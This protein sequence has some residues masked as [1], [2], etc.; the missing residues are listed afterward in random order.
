L[1]NELG[2]AEVALSFYQLQ[3]PDITLKL[4]DGV[5]HTHKGLLTSV[6]PVFDAMFYGNFKEA[7]EMEVDLPTD[8]HKT[9]QQVINII[10]KGSCELDSFDDSIALKEVFE[11]YQINKAPFLHMCGEAILSQLDS[12]NYLTLLPKY[13]SVMSEESHKKAADKV[14]SYTNNDFVT[15]F[16]ETKDL[17]GEV[18]LYLLKRYDVACH[19]IEIFTFLVK[20]YD[21]QTK[22]SADIFQLAFQLFKYVRYSLII[23]QV[24]SSVVA[25]C[26]LVDTKL[27]SKAFEYMYSSCSPIGEADNSIGESFS[28]CSRKPSYPARVE[29]HA[30]ENVTIQCDKADQSEI[31][32]FL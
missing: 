24:L 8:T 32:F 9:I 21:Y 1:R 11:R 12:F 2:F 25:K 16:D 20:W 29:W 28:H 17:P 6:S 5:I 4:K 23:P 7:N 14:M 27:L 26:P 19:E 13:V 10:Y 22:K 30:Q 3:T 15:K 18:L 31:K